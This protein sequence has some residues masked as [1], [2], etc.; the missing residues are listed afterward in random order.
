MELEDISEE[1]LDFLDDY[2]V[3]EKSSNTGKQTLNN[4]SDMSSSESSESD[5]VRLESLDSS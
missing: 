2:E 5:S 1:E 3:K 4:I